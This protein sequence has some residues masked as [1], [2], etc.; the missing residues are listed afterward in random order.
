MKITPTIL[1]RQIPIEFDETK[2]L[3]LAERGVPFL[4]KLRDDLGLD[5]L[6]LLNQ[7]PQVVE[8][9]SVELPQEGYVIDHTGAKVSVQDLTSHIKKVLDDSKPA[10]QSQQAPQQASVVTT[11]APATSCAG[12]IDSLAGDIP[13]YSRRC[14]ICKVTPGKRPHYSAA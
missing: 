11:P 5:V 12:C 6:G 13:G 14:N 9:K 2:A 4:K 8:T 10:A 1:G 7:K 3:T